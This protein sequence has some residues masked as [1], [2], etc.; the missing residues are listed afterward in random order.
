MTENKDSFKDFLKN[1]FDFSFSVMITAEVVKI[2]YIIA[3]IASALSTICLVESGGNKIVMLILAPIAFL[4][5]V[6]FARIMME[7]VIVIF[8]IAENTNQLVRNVDDNNSSPYSW[9]DD[10]NGKKALVVTVE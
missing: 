8:K 9:P 7:L 5:Q 6:L 2:L 1:L 10:R 3:V 4:L